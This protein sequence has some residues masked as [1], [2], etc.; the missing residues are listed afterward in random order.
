MQAISFPNQ[1]SNLCPLHWEQR[2]FTT[3]LQRKLKY[4]SYLHRFNS[5]WKIYFLYH[6]KFNLAC[7]LIHVKFQS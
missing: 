4:S 5:K 2:V 1:G 6:Y 3:G 7:L